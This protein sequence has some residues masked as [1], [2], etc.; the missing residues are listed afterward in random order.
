METTAAKKQEPAVLKKKKTNADE[1][2]STCS[3]DGLYAKFIQALS[4]ITYKEEIIKPS[5][6]PKWVVG[7]G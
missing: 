7:R 1:I 2:R 5:I 3:A 6:L 4:E